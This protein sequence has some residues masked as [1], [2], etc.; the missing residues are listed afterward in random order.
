MHHKRFLA[1]ALA[2]MCGVALLSASSAARIGT[3]P[4]VTAPAPAPPLAF[5]PGCTLPFDA[6]KTQGL[7]IDKQCGRDG[8]SSPSSASGKQNEVKNNFCAT[9]TPT[10]LTFASFDQLQ[11]AASTKHIPFGSSGLPQN[12]GVLAG[13]ITVSGKK[14][15]EGSV[16]TVEGIVFDA[17]HSNT[18]L[19]GEGGESVNCNS[20]DLDMN[21]IHIE[22]AESTGQS[23]CQTVTA[24]I[25]PH[26]RPASWN[27]FDV[28]PTEGPKVNG[29]PLKGSRVRLTGQLFFDASHSPCVNGHGSAPR[30]RSIWEVHPVYAIDVFDAAKNKFVPLD[31]WAQ[32]K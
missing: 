12:R 11:Q 27:R 23:E 28:N 2:I 18:T 17:R 5:N 14:V 10:V 21:D 3:I 1:F 29:L 19:L 8:S 25:S 30:R 31:V 20:G 15:G 13:L 7:R 4:P 22:L 16:V 9:G 32:G 26:F 6:I 24:E